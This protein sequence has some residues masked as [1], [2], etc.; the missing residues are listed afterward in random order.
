MCKLPKV[1]VVMP[2]FNHANYIEMGIKSVLG[3]SYANIQLIVVDDGSTDNT[4][5]IIERL[6]KDGSFVS[7]R[8]K[9]GGVCSALNRG[10]CEADGDFIAVIASDD[11]FLENKIARQVDFFLDQPENVG[12]VHSGAY[13]DYQNNEGLVDITGSYPP[14]I[15]SCLDEILTQKF[16][17]VAPTIIFRKSVYD[18]VGGFDEELEAEDV[19]FFMRVAQAGYHFAYINE[20]L[21]IKTVT[22]NSAG[23]NFE[24]LIKVHENILEKHKENITAE[25]YA[26]IKMAMYDHLIILS[27]S[28]GNYMLAYKTAFSLTQERRSLRPL[29]GFSFWSTRALIVRVLPRSC[30]HKLRLL[31]S[32]L[33]Q[34][35]KWAF[36]R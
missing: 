22:D 30:R 11:R 36:V 9:N 24:K 17:I 8:K 26:S 29:I 19:D 5:E 13:L 16:R 3:Q 12:L 20:P 15:G 23:S 27:A 4:W 33:I 1:S 18:K 2:A 35:K 10:I 6:N 31:R 7:I 32:W 25:Q 14:A 21:V 28:S 34:R